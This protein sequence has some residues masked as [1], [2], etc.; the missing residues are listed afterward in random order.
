[1][2]AL[3]KDGYSDKKYV[4]IKICFWNQNVNEKKLYYHNMNYIPIICCQLL[5]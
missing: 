4:T 2:N 1:M 5:L 3:F